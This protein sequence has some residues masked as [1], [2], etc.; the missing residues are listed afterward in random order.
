VTS[1][2]FE[3]Q[4]TVSTADTM[5]GT[6]ATY[7]APEGAPS[8]PPRISW[9]AVIAGAVVAVIVGL[10]L[11]VLGV[12]VGASAVDATSGDTPSGTT[13]ASSPASGCWWPT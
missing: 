10:M 2:E 6:T 5:T 7:A 9:G 8:L 1:K 13:L 12:A 11:N 4:R 3:M